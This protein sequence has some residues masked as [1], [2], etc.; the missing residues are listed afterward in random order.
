MS[1]LT[2]AFRD[3]A[4]EV[5]AA[6]RFAGISA[7]VSQVLDVADRLYVRPAPEA[8]THENLVSIVLNDAGGYVDMYGSNDPHTTV[9]GWLREGKKIHAIKR[10]R[11]KANCSLLDAKNA[12]EDDRVMRLV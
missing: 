6:L 3:F 12:V 8:T 4:A 11:A 2:P 9:L 5:D 10:L 1:N 7:H